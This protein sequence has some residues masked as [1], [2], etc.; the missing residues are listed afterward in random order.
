MASK[1]QPP[2]GVGGPADLAAVDVVTVLQALSDPVRLEIVRQL[3][4]CGRAGELNCGRIEVP[5]SK[6]TT[7]HHL[8]TLAAA[9][10][11]AEREEGTRKYLRLRQPDL[12]RRFPGLIDSILHAAQRT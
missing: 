1:N 8:R 10:I 7:S 3:A 5:V 11:I 12:D 9:G 6:S 2:T 4:A